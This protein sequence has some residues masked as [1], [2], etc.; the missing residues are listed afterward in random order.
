VSAANDTSDP[1]LRATGIGG[2]DAAAILGLSGYGTPYSVAMEKVAGI[3][4]ARSEE[5]QERL[6]WGKA[7]EPLIIAAFERKT[8]MRVGPGTAWARL[9][10]M[11]FLFANVD[12]LIPGADDVEHWGHASERWSPI[13][14]AEL[15][16]LGPG[17]FEGKCA[18]ADDGWGTARDPQVPTS[19][20]AQAQHYM[21]V[22]DRRWTG[23]GALINGNR[24]EVRFVLRDDA[25]LAKVWL[26]RLTEFWENIQAGRLPDPLDPDV[27]GPVLRDRYPNGAGGRKA[28]DDAETRAVYA[29]QTA[30][31]EAARSKRLS[32]SLGLRVRAIMGDHSIGT[33]TTGEQ[34][35]YKLTAADSRTLRQPHK[36]K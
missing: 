2:S 30:L 8:G 5:E 29:W 27:D 4:E 9:P 6:D 10:G 21:A 22:L 13:V 34:I 19:Y 32:E 3:K 14:P 23:F 17:I 35:T 18:G 25:W 31:E 36:A 7:L 24:L 12:G 33:L 15:R 26:P 28:L 20:W 16:D 11:P 1:T